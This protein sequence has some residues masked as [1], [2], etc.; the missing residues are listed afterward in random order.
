MPEI[1]RIKIRQLL[2]DELKN[3][4][5]ETLQR[6]HDME[7]AS[8]N[9]SMEKIR[10]L[11]EESSLDQLPLG[12][13][14]IPILL[15]QKPA[16]GMAILQRFVKDAASIDSG[17]RTFFAAVALAMLQ[18]RDGIKV[19]KKPHAYYRTRSGHEFLLAS[20]A[21]ALLGEKSLQKKLLK[22]SPRKTLRPALPEALQEFRR[23]G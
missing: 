21:A 20:A 12:F 8:M 13:P 11:W 18:S 23:S 16:A 15:L 17:T 3:F 1:L 5:L 6:N 7:L 14:I 10:K 9:W 19:L 2:L 4:Y 22:K